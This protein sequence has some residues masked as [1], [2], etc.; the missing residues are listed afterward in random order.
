MPK[1]SKS[2]EQLF[3][4]AEAELYGEAIQQTE[5]EIFDDALGRAP[6]ENDGDDSL[7][8]MDD[9]DVPTGD[10]EPEDDAEGDEP[11]ES[12]E[13]EGEGE[14]EGEQEQ[15]QRD[16]REAERSEGRVPS[17]RLRESNEARRLA[18]AERDAERQ[19]LRALEAEIELLK[20]GGAQQRQQ[21]QQDEK[22]DIFA[23]PEGRLKAER[24]SIRQDIRKD[25]VESSL[26]DAADEHGEQ[27]QT[28]YQSLIRAGQSGDRQTVQQI[29]DSPNP[30]RALM[31]WHDRQSL[32][33]DIGTDPAAYRSKVAQELL[34]DPEFRKQAL[35]SM[36]EEAMNGERGAPRTRVRLPA[37][38]N[39]ASGGAGHR[40]R[41]PGPRRGGGFSVSDEREIADSVWE[42]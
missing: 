31:R 8:R 34:G 6:D 9:D 41:D 14:G 16:A 32:L 24:D 28:A 1:K 33:R 4:E 13:G 35:E 3:E 10:E 39:G 5:Q 12:E 17:Q 40:S 2:N 25:W 15:D 36:R 7:E 23:D 37:S 27:F 11:D 26:A 20:R 42:N 22:L 18:E 29:W 38:L 21:P 30:G 19:R